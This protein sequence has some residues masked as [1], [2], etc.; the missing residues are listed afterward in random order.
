MTDNFM[1][2]VLHACTLKKNKNI[3]QAVDKFAMSSK[4]LHELYFYSK[5]SK[6]I[7]YSSQTDVF[8]IGLLYVL[9]F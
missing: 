1:I 8:A 6:L 4:E 9:H 7:I 3:L 2:I 5:L